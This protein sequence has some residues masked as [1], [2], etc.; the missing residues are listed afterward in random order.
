M[1]RPARLKQVYRVVPPEDWA[2]DA[3]ELTDEALKAKY[4]HMCSMGQR[5]AGTPEVARLW[6]E[7]AA[8]LENELNIR[9]AHAIKESLKPAIIPARLPKSST[10]PEALP[11][12][13]RPV[14][15][16]RDR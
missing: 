1:N 10:I 3:A 13:H 15:H 14:R 9:V 16:S 2:A 5:L 7:W 6:V 4:E 8:A 11:H 12:D